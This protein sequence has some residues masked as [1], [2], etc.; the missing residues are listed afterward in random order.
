[1]LLME[2]AVTH[3]DEL[4]QSSTATGVENTQMYTNEVMCEEHIS[5]N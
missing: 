5:R 3:N 1:M 2:I 4:L